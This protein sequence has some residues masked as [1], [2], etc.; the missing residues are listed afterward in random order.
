MRNP[1]T[2][3]LASASPRRREILRR[4]GL[5][6][7]VDES[8]YEEADL[9]GLK[10]RALAEFHALHKARDVAR[11]HR[12]AIVLAADTIIV[13]KGRRY[14]K[15]RDTAQAAEMLKALSGK[16]HSVITG[17]A[18]I[19]T[20]DSRE[21]SGSVETKVFFRRLTKDEITA[22][23][24]SGEPLDKA[25]AY[26]IQGLGGVLVEKIEGDF[27]NVV[28]LPL[29]AVSEGLKKFGVSV[30]QVPAS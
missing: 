30:L 12:N 3:I 24:N 11:R 10:P 5:K 16:A 28:G 13:L 7:S 9:P 20:A 29:S 6:F 26:G 14:G 8:S 2:I 21:L 4:T 19:D 27:S 18:I 25:G 15:P 17:F 22:Y 23:V 1:K